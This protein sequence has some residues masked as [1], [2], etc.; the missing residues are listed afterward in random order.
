MYNSVSEALGSAVLRVTFAVCEAYDNV[1][2]RMK[3]VFEKSGEATFEAE[4]LGASHTGIEDTINGD[5]I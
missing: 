4:R 1:R 2:E 3:K 5:Y